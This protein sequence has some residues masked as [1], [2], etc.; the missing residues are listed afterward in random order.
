MVVSG[1]WRVVH[2]QS[3]TAN[4]QPPIANRQNPTAKTQQPTANSQQLTAK[5]QK[6][7]KL[8]KIQN[9]ATSYRFHEGMF[10]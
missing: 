9:M 5:N 8:Q 4:S 10:I 7:E 2:S 1:D 3:P 6:H